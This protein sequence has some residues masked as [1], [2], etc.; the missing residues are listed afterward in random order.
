[1]PAAGRG[2]DGAVAEFGAEGG[3]VAG[4]AVGVGPLL[5]AGHDD[6]RLVDRPVL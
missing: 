5:G 1:M 4:V 2:Q 3:V 6:D